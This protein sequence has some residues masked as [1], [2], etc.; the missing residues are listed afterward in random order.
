MTSIAR[1]RGKQNIGKLAIVVAALAVVVITLAALMIPASTEEVQVFSATDS[2]GKV[3]TELSLYYNYNY[4]TQNTGLRVSKLNASG[5]TDKVKNFLKFDAEEVVPY[6]IALYNK[7]NTSQEY[8]NLWFQYKL[9]IDV[10]E[11]LFSSFGPSDYIYC[12]AVKYGSIESV[13]VSS[14]RYD[15]AGNITKLVIEGSGYPSQNEFV[16]MRTSKRIEVKV[17]GQAL[18][19]N[20]QKDAFRL[21][22]AYEKYHNRQSPI[23]IA[24]S[25]HIVAFD[26]ANLNTHTNGNVLAKNLYAT[27]NFGT[28]GLAD[29]LTY[30]QNYC[31]VNGGSGSS[32]DHVLVV[33]SSASVSTADNNNYWSISG[34]KL[35][36]PKRLIQDDNTAKAPFIDLAAVETEIRSVSARINSFENRN[37]TTGNGEIRLTQK[38][39][40]GVIDFTADDVNG[41]GFRME[42]FSRG[43]DGTIIVNVD[44]AGR[45]S[46]S[47]EKARIYVDGADGGLGEVTDFSNGKV[48]WNFVNADGA[49]INL[50]EVAGMI[51]APGAT[52]N[53][54]ANVNGTIVA[55]IVNVNAE[56]H[57]TDFTGILEVV[58][59]DEY[60]IKFTKP[61]NVGEV[62][63]D[64][65]LDIYEWQ[66][67][68]WVKVDDVTTDEN[69]NVTLE[70]LKPSTSYTV[71]ED[72]RTPDDEDVIIWI[73]KGSEKLPE[74]RP[75]GDHTY[76]IVTP[77]EIITIQKEL[78]VTPEDPEDEP[79]VPQ[80]PQTMNLVITKE[81][82]T[83]D[84]ETVGTLPEDITEVQVRIWQHA[85]G[86]K[87]LYGEESVYIS[88]DAGWQTVIE[89]LP[90]TGTIDGSPVEY[91]YSVQEI[92]I[93][94]RFTSSASEPVDATVGETEMSVSIT[95]TYKN[96][97]GYVLPDAG[98]M[99][100]APLMLAGL[101]LVV[102]SAG[103]LYRRKITDK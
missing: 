37:I 43:H 16:F 49:T 64:V 62:Y 102:I 2:T 41:K 8:E 79:A 83:A 74:S 97:E 84:G 33:G 53:L 36:R 61:G 91:T 90:L 10:P 60:V 59:D 32:A 51:L 6:K 98:G 76:E 86:G 18:E 28:N 73:P 66:D 93:D 94:E 12:G 100:T 5:Y 35:D 20:Y 68:E 22:S 75:P 103:L 14:V 89:G 27:S 26:T 30:A 45:S 34:T 15:S 58:P 39:G 95:N 25:F 23:G 82:K 21:D 63:P 24:G 85:G 7:Q 87:Y 88:R 92:N 42:G 54:D 56:S 77:G 81:W 47:I 71:V 96:E 48:I 70:E 101:C 52:V 99:G 67:D 1:H 9:E 17:N 80:E 55:D 31:K 57:R 11:G 72:G 4:T 3:N 46:V 44:C 65:D 78:E 29:E 50:K 19:Y 38:D 13:G 69:G 40:I